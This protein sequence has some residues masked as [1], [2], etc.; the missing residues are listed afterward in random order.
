MC[1]GE[2]KKYFDWHSIEITITTCE[3]FSIYFVGGGAPE[4]PVQPQLHHLQ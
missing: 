4:L 2:K 3:G 1:A